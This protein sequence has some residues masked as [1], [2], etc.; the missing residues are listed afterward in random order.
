MS[1]RLAICTLFEGGYHYGLGPLANSLYASGF[2]GIIWAGYRG[3]LPFWAQPV[4]ETGSYAEFQVAEGCAIHF[5]P[6]DT[7]A[8]LTNYKPDFM[9]RVFE[10]YAPDCAGLIYLDPDIIMSDP[11][12]SFEEWIGCGVA[13]CEDVNS[14]FAAHHPRRVGWRRFYEG[15][16][17]LLPK[18]PFYANGGFVGVRREDAAFLE[19]WKRLQDRLWQAIGGAEYS[20]FVGEKSVALQ[21]DYPSCFDKT[22]QD[23]LN[24]AIEAVEG[25]PVSFGNKQAMGFETGKAVLPH[26]LG[27]DKPWK[28]QYLRDALRG[29]ALRA[30]D[31]EYWL[32]A[33]GPIRVFTSRQLLAKRIVLKIS[34]VLGRFI[35]RS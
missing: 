20:G 15:T 12:R 1:K 14:P 6:L 17:R 2:R 32:H 24:A 30:V 7:T 33:Q 23:V 10:T 34:A 21:S 16:A 13:V 26:A 35:R 4:T 25:I 28:K 11:W 31:K 8:H 29:A 19:L 9:L 22:D 3:A 5:V 27:P 18:E